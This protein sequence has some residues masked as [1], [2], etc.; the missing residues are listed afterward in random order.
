[1][2][3]V[4]QR[5]WWPFIPLTNYVSPLLHCEIGI[6]NI[7]FKLLRDVINEHIE[8]YVP[9]E[10]FIRDSIP[11][12]QQVIAST[13]TQRDQW[14]N[15]DDGNRLKILKRAV[16]AYLKCCEL[17]ARYDGIITD[18]EVRTHE[19]N[20]VNMKKTARLTQWHSRKAEEGPP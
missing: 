2:L 4:E 12:L 15:S 9:G 13:T 20:V 14:D 3:G 16:V 8:N 11:A 7:L 6:G 19:S 5:P 1:M 17:V 18:E 10:Q